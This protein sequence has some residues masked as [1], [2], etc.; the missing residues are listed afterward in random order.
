MN[1]MFD[2]NVGKLD[3]YMFSIRFRDVAVCGF[4]KLALKT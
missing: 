3:D 1:G 2:I 4:C